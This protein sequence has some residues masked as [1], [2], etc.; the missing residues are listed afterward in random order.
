MLW[1]RSIS[2]LFALYLLLGSWK[3]YV[4]LFENGREE[5]RQIF[6]CPV[7]S[8]PEADQQ[9]LAEKIPIRNDRDLQQALEDYLS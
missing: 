9:L 6:P 8:L 4:A 1:K 5:P 7:D 2:Y 3:G